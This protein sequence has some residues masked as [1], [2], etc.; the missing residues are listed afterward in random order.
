MILEIFLTLLDIIDKTTMAYDLYHCSSFRG[1]TTL[2]LV[3]Y[4]IP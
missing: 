1:A 2:E 4:Q 3:F